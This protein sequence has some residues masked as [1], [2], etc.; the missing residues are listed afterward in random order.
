MLTSFE[1]TNNSLQMNSSLIATLVLVFALCY[2]VNADG[3]CP[4][5]GDWDCD[6]MSVAANDPA[7]YHV[8]AKCQELEQHFF[9]LGYC[10]L[11]HDADHTQCKADVAG[12]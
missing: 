5:G 3:P 1:K 7:R 9:G 11:C 6:Y 8:C 4:N 12:K 2:V 10:C